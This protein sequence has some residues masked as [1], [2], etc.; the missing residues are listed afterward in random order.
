MKLTLYSDYS[1][2]VLMY[3]ARQEHRVQ[4][5]EIAKFYGISKNH[6]T[7]VV[8]NLA[9]LGYIETTRGRGGGIRIKMAPEEINI[10]ALIRKTEEHFNLVE[11]FD[12]ET[13]TCPI[14]GICGLQGVLGEA[15]NAYLSVLD[16]YTLQDILF[17]KIAL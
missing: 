2:R 1:L 10:G 8:N 9:T 3:V 4:I 12:R 16:K 11:C 17:R 6:L 13:N 5:D 7:K 14:A 15:L